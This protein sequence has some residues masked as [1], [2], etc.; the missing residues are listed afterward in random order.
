M[1][2]EALTMTI[3]LTKTRQAFYSK[4]WSVE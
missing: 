4:W 1:Q 3:L 2:P